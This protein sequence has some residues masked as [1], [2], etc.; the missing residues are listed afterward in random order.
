M[1]LIPNVFSYYAIFCVTTAICII[2]LNVKAFRAVGFSWNLRGGFI[3]YGIST[4]VF[5]VGAPLFFIIFIFRSDKYYENLKGY[6]T[7][8]Y[9]DSDD[10]S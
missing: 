10:E 2:H 6:I 8:I 7:E 5:L 1:E 3:Y 9:L 4:P